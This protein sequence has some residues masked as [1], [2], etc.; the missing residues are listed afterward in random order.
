MMQYYNCFLAWWFNVGVQVFFCISGFLY[1]QREKQDVL[2]FFCHRF[3]KIILPYWITVIIFGTVESIFFSDVFS[4]K[5]LV[6]A[7]LARLTIPGGEHLWFIPVILMCYIIT[8]LL[9]EVR[10]E[11]EQKKIGAVNGTIA[12]VIAVSLFFGLFANYFNPAWISCYVIGYWIGVNKKQMLVRENILLVIFTILALPLNLLQGYISYLL[13]PEFINRGIY[14][15]WCNYNHVWLGVFLFLLGMRAFGRIRF[16]RKALD[17]TDR[18]SYETYLVHQFF[19]LGP[20]SL[21]A[22][23][24]WKFVNILII[25]G[26]IVAAAFIL[27]KL[28]SIVVS[29]CTRLRR[30]IIR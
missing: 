10:C 23:T 27:K 19:I 25:Y 17:I 13:K 11:V 6:G 21:M 2:D 5:H 12:T 18:Y 22:L 28:E 30:Q 16:E 26:C 9:N 14:I 8:P 29:F 3:R 4:I 1:G 15:Y 7:L 24:R 20:M